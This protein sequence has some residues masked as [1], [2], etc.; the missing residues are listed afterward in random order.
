MEP[1]AAR[2]HGLGRSRFARGCHRCGYHDVASGG[3]AHD[4]QDRPSLRVWT[5]RSAPLRGAR[6]RADRTITLRVDLVRTRRTVRGV[7]NL[8]VRQPM[9]GDHR[10]RSDRTGGRRPPEKNPAGFR[11]NEVTASRPDL[12]GLRAPVVFLPLDNVLW[13]GWLPDGHPQGA[14]D[15]PIL[16][17]P[18]TALEV[19][20]TWVDRLGG[21]LLVKP[22][23]SCVEASKL[24]LPPVARLVDGSL[25][26]I[27]SAVDLTV[28][29][30]TK[31]RSRRSPRA[32]EPRRSPTTRW[33]PAATPRTG[34]TSPRPRTR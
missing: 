16:R 32:S 21:T 15:Y 10:R 18:A 1:R 8:A 20:G 23:P 30:N 33:P 25:G 17:S 26:E 4:E 14:T 11:S 22:H 24:C 34:R 12:G 27:L 31:V 19:I 29:F 6:R 13:T 5:C 3:R 2:T 28:A 9:A 7:G